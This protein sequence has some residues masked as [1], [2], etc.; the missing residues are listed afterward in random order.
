MTRKATLTLT[1]GCALAAMALAQEPKMPAPAAEHQKLAYFAG[2][3]KS[4]GEMK[5]MGP[6]PGGKFTGTDHS[7]LFPGGFFV[8]TRS[9]GTTPMGPLNELSIMGYDDQAKTYTYSSFSNTGEHEVY[10][11]S[12]DGDTWTWSGNSDFGGKMFKGRFISKVVS[13]TVYTYRFDYS[14]DGTS[15]TNIMEGKATKAE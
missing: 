1:M 9:T 12:V 7:E 2:T 10:T 14:P 6:F 5:P 15:W 3:W 11:G 4:E 8:V 13:R